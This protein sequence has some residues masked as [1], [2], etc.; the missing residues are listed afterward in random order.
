M[1][2]DRWSRHLGVPHFVAQHGALTP[3]MPPLPQAARLLAWTEVDAHYWAGGRPDVSYKAVGSQLLW[4]AGAG[5]GSLDL[6]EAA[7]ELTY[8]GQMHGAELPRNQLVRAAASFCREHD[9][10][11]RPHPSERD[12]LSRLAHAGYRRMGIVVDGSKPLAELTGPVVS[13]F[14]TGVLE[15][16]AHGR[17]AWVD[18]PRP[19]DWLGEFWER[20][21]MHRSGDTPTPPPARP[22]EEPARGIARILT[23][24]VA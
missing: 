1:V 15:A 5:Q 7:D 2:A 19:P 10:I 22:A 9:A 16:A 13:V 4:D 18:F 14:S 24:A 21:D 17:H 3:F 12:K 20:Y 8:L 23:D 6:T 11:Y